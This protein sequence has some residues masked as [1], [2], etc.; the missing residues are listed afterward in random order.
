MRPLEKDSV[1]NEIIFS[2]SHPLTCKTIGDR[3]TE[4]RNCP[5]CLKSF[6]QDEVVNNLPC[7]HRFH[8]DCIKQWLKKVCRI[9][10]SS[11]LGKGGLPPIL[12]AYYL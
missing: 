3:N 2:L 4:D 5:I 7:N 6:E 12:L 8:S 1:H 11:E 10:N 9:G